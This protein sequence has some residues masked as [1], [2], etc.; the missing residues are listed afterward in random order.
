ML[1]KRVQVF[2]CDEPHTVTVSH[3][4]TARWI[5]HGEYLGKSVT[6]EDQTEAAAL[7]RWRATAEAAAALL[8][9]S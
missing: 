8:P 4:F 7:Q 3:R 9:S 1:R 5:A 2:V 6:V